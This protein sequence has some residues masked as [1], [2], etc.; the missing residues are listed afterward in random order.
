MALLLSVIIPAFNVQP[1]VEYAIASAQAQAVESMEIIVIDDGSSDGTAQAVRRYLE[2][3]RIRLLANRPDAHGPSGARNT[4]LRTATGKYIGFLDADDA[5]LPNKV[6]R[7]IEVMERR[8]DV[9]LTF[10]R[11]R[12]VS[13]DGRDTGR[14]SP[15]PPGHIVGIEDLL[16]ENIVG[17]SS[18]VICRRSAVEAAGLFDERL[19]AAVDLDLWLRIA[20]LRQGNLLAIN[21]VLTEYRLREGQI[22][23]DWRRMARNWEAVLERVRRQMPDRVRRVERKA[24]AAHFRYRAYLAYEAGEFAAARRQLAHA[25]MAASPALLADR[26]TWLTTAAVLGSMLPVRLHKGLA[27]RAKAIRAAAK[28]GKGVAT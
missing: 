27:R 11:W 1:F 28:F 10:S 12:T 7:H 20:S 22:T 16:L 13:C 17:G 25:F 21:E 9:D 5:W 3:G 6:R 23:K 19:S 2:D 4:G 14:V 26:R 15:R 18:N 24:R 8:P